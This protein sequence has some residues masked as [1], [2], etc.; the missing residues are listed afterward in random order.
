MG[1]HVRRTPGRRAAL[2]LGAAMVSTVMAACRGADPAQEETP[3]PAST[4]EPQDAVDTGRTLLEDAQNAL[5]EAFEDLDWNEASPAGTEPRDGGCRWTSPTRR[6]D[7]HLGEDSEDH[8]RIADA[9]TSALS[10]HG[11]PAAPVP[12]G[13]TGGWLTTSS[14]GDGITLSFRSKGYAELAVTVDV[15][16]DCSALDAHSA[17]R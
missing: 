1:E 3:M 8:Q 6:C 14:T 11:L 15:G 9:L 7:T 4:E 10:A 17:P 16:G 5:D 13:G 12:T 2:V